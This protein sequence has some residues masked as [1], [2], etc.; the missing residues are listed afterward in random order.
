MTFIIYKAN[1]F[2]VLYIVNISVRS[3][4]KVSPLIGG[5]GALTTE[6]AYLLIE[7]IQELAG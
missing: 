6:Q 3:L 5:W 7:A 4:R 2:S 1:Q